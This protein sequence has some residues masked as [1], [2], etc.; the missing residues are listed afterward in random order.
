MDDF[1][2]KYME[3]ILI[4][5]LGTVVGL[6]LW[7]F[8]RQVK[9]TDDAIHNIADLKSLPDRIESLSSVMKR[10]ENE[11]TDLLKSAVRR[12]DIE[13]IWLEVDRIQPRLDHIDT[14]IAKLKVK[15]DILEKLA[16]Y[17]KRD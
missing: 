9:D 14:E 8:K 12:S 15:S 13:R 2:S 7:I 11:Y 10:L 6:V 17:N 5:L 3:K 16:K 4:G 1:F